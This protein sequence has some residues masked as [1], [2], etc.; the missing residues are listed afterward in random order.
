DMQKECGMIGGVLALVLAPVVEGS[1]SGRKQSCGS[2][3][4]EREYK[5]C[6]TQDCDEDSMDFRAIQC[7]DFNN[8]PFLGKVYQWRPYYDGEKRCSLLCSAVNTSVY[9]EWSDKVIDGTKC[10]SLSDD[11]CVDGACQAAGCDNVLGSRARRDVCGVCNGDGQS[12]KLIRGSFTIPQL[13]SGYNE[14]ITLPKGSTSISLKEMKFSPNYLVLKSSDETVILSGEHYDGKPVLMNIG[15]TSLL[16]TLEGSGQ[17]VVKKLTGQ[18]PT[19]GSIQIYMMAKEEKN[20]GVWYELYIPLSGREPRFEPRSLPISYRQNLHQGQAELRSSGIGE[21][22]QSSFSWNFGGWT[23]CS[24]KC[25]EGIRKRLVVCTNRQT[26]ERSDLENCDASGRPADTEKCMGDNCDETS[27]DEKTVEWKLGDWGPCSSSC[28]I[29]DQK[30]SVQC[31][32][33]DPRGESLTVEDAQCIQLYGQKPEYRRSCNENVPCPYWTA[34]E[35]SSC[36]K[37]C[38]MGE[39]TRSV[40]CISIDNR[41]LAESACDPTK[42]PTP[43][44]PCMVKQCPEGPLENCRNSLFGCCPD[45]RTPARGLNLEG[46][47]G[48]CKGTRYGCCPDQRTTARGPNGEGCGSDCSRSRYGCCPNSQNPAR[49]PHGEG[50]STPCSRYRYGCCPDNVT[51]A[52]G[53]NGEGCPTSCSDSQYGC[54]PDGKTEKR[55]PNNEGCSNDCSRYPYGCCSDNITPARGPN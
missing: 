6:T 31:V 39:Q 43:T 10:D 14:V 27:Q 9:H 28:D 4:E 52:R 17:N 44:R 26:G 33:G 23:Q 32:S 29:G 7:Q 3:R 22:T 54:C 40:L 1:K 13:Y 11:Q 37:A 45:G 47:E 25:G 5:S 38:G 19:K 36:N 55:G 16:Y 49:G 41:R 2:A 42:K 34:M 46:C 53:P 15:G 20:P 12:Y 18:G 35:W 8:V 50:C 48:T 51:V 24:T 30:Q 21:S